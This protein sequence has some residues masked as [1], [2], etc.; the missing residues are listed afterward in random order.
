MPLGLLGLK[1]GMTQ[2]YDEAGNVTPRPISFTVAW[3]V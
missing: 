1:V 3:C 2:V